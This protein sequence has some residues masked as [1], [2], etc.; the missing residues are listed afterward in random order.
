MKLEQWTLPKNHRINKVVDLY[1]FPFFIL[2]RDKIDLLND[3]KL[4][5]LFKL[6]D[7]IEVLPWP[8]SN[9]SLFSEEREKIANTH[10]AKA[11]T[12]IILSLFILEMFGWPFTHVEKPS[13]FLIKHPIKTPKDLKEAV[14]IGRNDLY[15]IKSPWRAFSWDAN[16]LI[17]VPYA[18]EENK[19][20]ELLLNLKGWDF[21]EYNNRKDWTLF[22]LLDN[23]QTDLNSKPIKRIK[24]ISRL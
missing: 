11:Q 3:A 15:D 21:L 14:D 1:V 4:D 13:S 17:G 22:S 12:Q 8:E 5:P 18:F 2:N 9:V 6:L 20:R 23:G 16:I 7:L 24:I 10:L 19:G